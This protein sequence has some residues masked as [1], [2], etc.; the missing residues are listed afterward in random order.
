M[1]KEQEKQAI[2]DSLVE[3]TQRSEAPNIYFSRN[4]VL[5]N[6]KE[7]IK[8][9]EGLYHVGRRKGYKYDASQGNPVINL[10]LVLPKIKTLPLNLEELANEGKIQEVIIS[11]GIDGGEST[12]KLYRASEDKE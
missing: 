4:D 6:I 12:L 3:L 10:D 1:K 2:Y 5:N 7:N 8:E 9:K 11:S